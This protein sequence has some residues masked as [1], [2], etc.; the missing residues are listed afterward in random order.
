LNV[1]LH[2]PLKKLLEGFNVKRIHGNVDQEITAITYDSRQV[3]PGALFVSIKGLKTDGN[4]FIQDAVRAGSQAVLSEDSPSTDLPQNIC[5]V[6][7]ENARTALSH[8]ANRFYNDPTAHLQL[9]GITGTNGKTTLSF[10]MESILQA[11]ALRSGVIGTINYR[12]DGKTFPAKHTTP[13]SSDLYNLLNEMRQTTVTHA[14]M[15]VS[16][17]ALELGR[18]QDCRFNVAILTNITQDHLDFH[19]DIPNYIKAKARLFALLEE[20]GKNHP[21]AVI[22]ADDPLSAPV[23]EAVRKR[24]RVK[25]LS[26]G[27]S[28]SA[29]F[30]VANVNFFH[31]GFNAEIIAENSKHLIRSS[32][33]GRHNLY[34]CLAAIA[35]ARG[36]GIDWKNIELGIASL[37]NVPGRLECIS[38]DQGVT[39]YIDYAHSEDALA[40]VLQALQ[41]IRQEGQGGHGRI[42]TVFGC[43]GDRDRKK[44]SRMGEITAQMSD[45]VVVTSDN[46]RSEDPQQIIAEITATESLQ[47]LIVN[48]EAFLRGREQRQPL[49]AVLPDRREA[50]RLALEGGR[51]GDLLLIAGKGHEDYQEIKGVRYPFSDRDVT[52]SL[53]EKLGWKVVSA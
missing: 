32:L 17:H 10:L 18:V 43:G 9:I 52:I 16:S 2:V 34:N 41:T 12:Y 5:V 35:A 39:A 4:K 51:R 29:D 13:E 33:V 22:N 53:I 45:R 6:E 24:N 36:L 15:E 8:V 25:L 27:M 48:P 49:A 30:R 37:K 46:P 26:F 1:K 19:G 21:V 3:K 14:V 28:Q 47:R 20:R 44:R 42:I 23:L 11:A 38:T 50:I 40:N 31:N 7:V